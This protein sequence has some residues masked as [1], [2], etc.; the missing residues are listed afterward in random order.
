MLI[1]KLIIYF[2]GLNCWSFSMQHQNNNNN[3]SIIDIKIRNSYID[4]YDQKTL[5]F[6]TE[7]VNNDDKEQKKKQNLSR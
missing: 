3:Y 6:E 2:I 5:Y 4:K 7:Y 1:L